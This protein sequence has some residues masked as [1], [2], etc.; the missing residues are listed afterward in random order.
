MGDAT[1]SLSSTLAD[2][3][4]GQRHKQLTRSRTLAEATGRLES[5]QNDVASEE[6]RMEEESEEQEAVVQDNSQAW[7]RLLVRL[8]PPRAPK[9]TNGRLS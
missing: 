7:T 3:S 1:A 9:A 5:C 8:D 6:E 4:T 2:R